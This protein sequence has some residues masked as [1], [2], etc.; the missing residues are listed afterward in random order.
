MVWNA[1]EGRAPGRPLVWGPRRDSGK[2]GC[3]IWKELLRKSNSGG[4]CRPGALSEAGGG[5][6]PQRR[7]RRTD[8]PR[9]MQPCSPRP[10]WAGVLLQASSGQ[11]PSTHIAAHSG[12][13][14]PRAFP[15]STPAEDSPKQRGRATRFRNVP[16]RI[17]RNRAR[18]RDRVLSAPSRGRTGAPH[19]VSSLPEADEHG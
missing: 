5:F 15:P 19:P 6:L 18:A 12:T 1:G 16:A 13:E 10:G 2:N 4:T 14:Q 11:P 7:G 9:W 8:G 3:C 17:Q